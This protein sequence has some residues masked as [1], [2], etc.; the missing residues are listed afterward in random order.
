MKK[1]LF[2]LVV[3]LLSS[4]MS[5]AQPDGWVDPATSL[6]KTSTVIAD[7]STVYYLKNEAVQ[8]WF[9][10]GNNWWTQACVAGPEKEMPETSPY[11][12]QV[13]F[14]DPDTYAGYYRISDMSPDGLQVKNSWVQLFDNNGTIYSD[15]G[16]KD[17]KTYWKLT[18]DGDNN[19]TFVSHLH[20]SFNVG[21]VSDD[22]TNPKVFPADGSTSRSGG[23]TTGDYTMNN[24]GS[25]V[26]TVW[27]LW[28]MGAPEAVAEW[29]AGIALLNRLQ[30]I[31]EESEEAFDVAPY[32]DQ[33][34]SQLGTLENAERLKSVLAQLN[35]DY[36]AWQ[37]EH[38][39]PKNPADVTELYIVNPDFETGNTNGWT[40][41]TSN[42]HGAKS[43]TNDT[44][45]MTGSSGAYLF[46]I[47]SAG[48]EVSQTS[49]PIPVGV[50]KLT[51]VMAT[52]AGHNMVLTAGENSASKPSVEKGTG[53]LIELP[54]VI[55]EENEGLKIAAVTADN[56]WYKVD[57]FKLYYTGTSAE[58]YAATFS[59]TYKDKA[60][61][62]YQQGLAEKVAAI[63]TAEGDDAIKAAY[64]AAKAYEDGDVAENIAAWAK[65]EQLCA[66]AV[67]LANDQDFKD[68]A[69]KLA[70]MVQQKYVISN[71]ADDPSTADLNEDYNAILDEMNNV[72]SHI[73]PGTD[74]TNT[75]LKNADFTKDLVTDPTKGWVIEGNRTDGCNWR[76]STA[77]KCGECWNGN[78]FDF[79]QIVEDAPVGV[80]QIQ[81]Q[82]FTRA[83]RGAASWGYYFNTQTGELLPQPNFQGWTPN[84]ANVYLNDN[85]GELSISYKHGHTAEEAFFTKTDTY[86]DPLGQYIYPDGMGSAGESF[87][88]GEYA[89]SAFGLV[90][91][92][93]D[94]MRIGVKGNNYGLDN[95]MCFAN[96]KLI[97]Q[98]FDADII[99]PEFQKAVAS[100]AEAH[101]GT[102][103]QGEL[104]ALQG[105]AAGVSLSDGKAMFDVLSKIYAFNT[106]KAAS[107][108]VFENLNNQIKDLQDVYAEYKETASDKAIKD[109]QALQAEATDAYAA[110]AEP[111]L[112]TVTTEDAQ[113]ILAKFEPVIAALKVPKSAG[114]DD[115]PVDFTSI[116]KNPNMA[117]A[118]GWT[119]ETG[120]MA[121]D[122]TNKIAEFF[123]QV[124]YNVYQQFTGLPEGLYEVTV[125]GYYRAGEIAQ[126][127][128]AIAAGTES[129]SMLYVINDNKTLVN[130]DPETPADTI[131][132]PL[133]HIAAEAI[134]EDPSISG[135]TTITPFAE[136]G[137]ETP[138]YMPNNLAS[139]AAYL[140]S[141]FYVNTIYFYIWGPDDTVTLGVK[142]E[143]P[144]VTND[145]T[146]FSN[147][148][149]TGYGNLSVKD[150]G[151]QTKSCDPVTPVIGTIPGDVNG[152]GEV[153]VGDLVSV[154]NFMAGEAGDI[155]KE[156]ADVNKDGEVNVGDMVTITNIMAGNE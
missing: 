79:Y 123:N 32:A 18:F 27:S 151:A 89:V 46:N 118:T 21:L 132:C 39:T 146:A 121:V 103:L 145:W 31:F 10:A 127:W 15:S 48:N 47:W 4:V 22:G 107:E 49:K 66:D 65:Y 11:G 85:T 144:A 90:A 29:N 111:N 141:G 61:Y 140:G 8:S 154:S 28:S 106:K 77:D 136:L 55:E 64:K 16:D 80:Y 58:S 114:T 20:P 142:K 92:Q 109:A 83:G 112:P 110:E 133:R 73:Q 25:E 30:E 2:L 99:K 125:Q 59:E 84:K 156:A 75:Y 128:P 5:F 72:K 155:T 76:I 152:D 97:Y 108:E 137:D 53:V 116:I 51:A 135:T 96:F 78:D 104:I 74:I 38:A 88:A 122:G 117:S 44:Y 115:D 71:T 129:N 139:G 153:N 1:N 101:I 143:G 7:G 86:T 95:W 50:Y 93:G 149:L 40:Y 17:E 26:A 105:E 57:N 147:W 68:F 54:F 13:R 37:L 113:K 81:V 60:S 43:T 150:T 3:G 33:I 45:K 148:K 52:D 134:N 102:E 36:L 70:G 100:L 41:Q 126:D 24:T 82:G 23:S 119:V 130:D 87:A 69:Q 62:M 14:S 63:R 35:S 6:V 138:W 67:I 91:K 19:F 120:N 98:G 131:N 56:F 124:N 9:V 12:H 42:D 94:K 34:G